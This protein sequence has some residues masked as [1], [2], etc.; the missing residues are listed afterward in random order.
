MQFPRTL[1]ILLIRGD[2]AGDCDSGA[3]GEEFGDLGDA[4]D[5][6]IAVF[7]R[8]AEVFVEAEADVVAVEAVGGE[9]E[10]E[11]VLLEGGCDGGFARGG[12]A[13]EPDCEAALFAVGVAF[14]AGEAVV[15]GD[16]AGGGS[17]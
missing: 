14:T 10:V 15:P 2:E 7:F 8:E 13:G 17:Q 9:A 5:V 11:E 4:A 6:L 12:E 16:V 3:V 1:S